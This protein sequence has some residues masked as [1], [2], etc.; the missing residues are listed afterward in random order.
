MLDYDSDGS[1]ASTALTAV[2]NLS[3]NSM[4]ASTANPTAPVM[5]YAAELASLKA[6]ISS[7]RTIITEAVAQLKSA[8]ASLPIPSRESEATLM[9]T[10]ME[11]DGNHTTET[12]MDIT[13]LI[14]DLKHDIA[15]VVLEMRAKFQQQ[16]TLLPTTKQKGT[17]VT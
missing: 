16:A 9:S 11:T 3:S 17:P 4:A 10:A 2:P 15:T 14:A 8:V 1:T 12:T 6:E 5:D 13:D 7:L